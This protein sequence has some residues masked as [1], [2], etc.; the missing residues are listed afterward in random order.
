MQMLLQVLKKQMNPVLQVS[1][2]AVSVHS[3]NYAMLYD[4]NALVL[5]C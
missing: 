4:V 3:V 5:A 2:V 1:F